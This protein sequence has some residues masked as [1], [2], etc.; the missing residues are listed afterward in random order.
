MFNFLNI[1]LMVKP[2]IVILG[3]LSLVFSSEPVPRQDVFLFCLKPDMEPLS[4]SRSESSFLVNNDD[5]NY[6]FSNN[7]ISNI[8]KWIPQ[9]TEIDR[10]GDIYLNRIYRVYIEEN[11]RNSI[12]FIINSIQG[13]SFVLYA[14][15][16]F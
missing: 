15:N 14:E 6:F 1:R 5:L 13:F 11:Y 3:V 16:E 12:D 9:A 8:E 10:D 2:L 4:I 7:G